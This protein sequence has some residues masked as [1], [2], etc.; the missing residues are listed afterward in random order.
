M[1]MRYRV[2][3]FVTYADDKG[4]RCPVPVGAL[5]EV[6]HGADGGGIMTWQD[7]SSGRAWSEPLSDRLLAHYTMSHLERVGPPESVGRYSRS[8]PRIRGP[9]LRHRRRV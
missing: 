4:R 6:S 7:P 5:V 9:E 2:V 8:N 3:G 1:P